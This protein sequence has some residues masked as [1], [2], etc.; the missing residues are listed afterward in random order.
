MTTPCAPRSVDCLHMA[1]G[2]P[3]STRDRQVRQPLGLVESAGAERRPSADDA[4]PSMAVSIVGV[5]TACSKDAL[6][7]SAEAVRKTLTPE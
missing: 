4:A 2:E 1:A 7:T 3:T 6:R 5:S